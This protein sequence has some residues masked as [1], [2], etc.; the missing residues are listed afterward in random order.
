MNVDDV[1]I[2][3]DT[4]NEDFDLETQQHVIELGLTFGF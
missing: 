2:D 4:G 3:D 1:E